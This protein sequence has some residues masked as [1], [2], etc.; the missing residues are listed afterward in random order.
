LRRCRQF[1]ASLDIVAY[2]TS[3]LIKAT[4]KIGT[5]RKSKTPLNLPP[6]GKTGEFD[7][8]I[9]KFQPI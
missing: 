1:Q 5:V 8:V 9:K 4:G 3:G 6:T 2:R 7:Q